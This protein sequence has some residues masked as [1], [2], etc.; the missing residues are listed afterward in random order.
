MGDPVFDAYCATLVT[1]L[2]DFAKEQSIMQSVG[3]SLLDRIGPAILITH[4]QGGCH[5]W[6]W[7]DSR[8]DLVK[9]I[10]A[11]EPSGPPFQTAM[12][13]GSRSKRY[14][15]TDIPLAYDPAPPPAESG[16]P[17]LQRQQHQHAASEQVCI[18]QQEPARK[19]TN[20][21]RIPVLVVTAEASSHASYDEFTVRFLRQAGV[22]AEHLKLADQGIHGNGHLSF[23]EMNN[24]E[25][26]PV[27]DKWIT[28][29]A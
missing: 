11:V 5:G 28:K 4:S 29:I 7:A 12:S 16:E 19:L 27:L 2:V 14:G 13:K 21:L 24:L 1:G 26:F 20:I 3:K 10:V 15:L 8:P 6:L 17:P 9:A 25:I 23:M 18:L 22:K